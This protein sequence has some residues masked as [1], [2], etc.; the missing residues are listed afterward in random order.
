[1]KKNNFFTLYSKLLNH[2]KPQGWWPSIYDGYHPNDYRF[3]K[4]EDEIF[5]ICLGVI[6]TQN[7]SFDAVTK[8]LKNIDKVCKI[9]LKEIK[10]VDAQTLKNAIKPSGYYNQK[11]SYIQ[12]FITFF[13][14]LK[15]KTPTRDELLSI[16]GIGNESADSILLYGY[17]QPQFV[18]D[19]YTKRVFLAHNLIKDDAKYMQIKK[20]VESSF[21]DIYKNQKDLIIAYNEFH[22]LIVAY[23][24]EFFSKKTKT[25]LQ[26]KMLL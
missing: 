4:D 20:D 26:P 13:E 22:A 17:N 15:G 16:K 7:T 3:N 10:K 14:S 19:A 2:Y 25:S 18:V 1:M 23:A 24:K 11:T 8:S 6:L 5:E 9:S 21:E 12:N